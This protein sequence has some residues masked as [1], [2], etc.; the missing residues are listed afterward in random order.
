VLTS[1]ANCLLEQ[2]TQS[3]RCNTFTPII[4][5]DFL[6][7]FDKLWQQGLLLKLNRLNCPSTYLVW[8]ANYFTNRTL[9]IDY[10]GIESELIKLERELLKEVALVQ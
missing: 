1:R 6:Q 2:V 8:I 10:G 7:A 4:Y 9:K 3:L 5:I